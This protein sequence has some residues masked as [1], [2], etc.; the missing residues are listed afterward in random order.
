MHNTFENS[1]ICAVPCLNITESKCFGSMLDINEQFVLFSRC[2]D[3]WSL[4]LQ[5]SM[6]EDT[7]TELDSELD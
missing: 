2:T 3:L 4:L 5:E 7:N 6:V 1:V